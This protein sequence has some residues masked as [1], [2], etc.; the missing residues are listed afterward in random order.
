MCE[1]ARVHN[2]SLN[3]LMGVWII[4]DYKLLYAICCKKCK[5]CI[6]LRIPHLVDWH[7]HHYLWACL[8]WGCVA[9]HMQPSGESSH[10]IKKKMNAHWKKLEVNLTQNV[11]PQSQDLYHLPLLQQCRVT[12]FVYSKF[13]YDI[14]I[15]IKVHKYS[16][17]VSQYCINSF[18]SPS[19]NTWI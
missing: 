17:K 19:N 15:C 8:Q 18:E 9:P 2:L 10:P 11:L 6:E 7:V 3:K 14:N 16:P 13:Q 4:Q 5:V 1:S 12:T